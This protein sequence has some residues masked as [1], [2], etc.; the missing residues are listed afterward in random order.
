[1]EHEAGRPR[2]RGVYGANCTLKDAQ[3]AGAKQ[4]D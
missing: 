3:R 4:V 2:L 1:M